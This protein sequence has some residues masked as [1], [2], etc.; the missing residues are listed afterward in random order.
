MREKPVAF[1]ESQMKEIEACIDELGRNT[2][3]QEI[4]LADI[5]GRLILAKGR[6][7][8]RETTATGVAALSAGGYAATVEMARYFEIETEFRQI[9]YEGEYHSIYSSNVGNALIITVVFDHSV[10]LGIVRAFTNQAAQCLQ[11][12]V[13]RALV[14]METDDRLPEAEKLGAEFGQA[15]MDEVEALLVEEGSQ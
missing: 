1:S 12:I 7:G 11:D 14:E 3:A 5:T 6:L 2:G 4:L 13:N 8:K 10:K 9:T 15:L